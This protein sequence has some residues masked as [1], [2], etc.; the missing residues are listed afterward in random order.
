MIH[1]IHV[2]HMVINGFLDLKLSFAA[3]LTWSTWSTMRQVVSEIQKVLEPPEEEVEDDAVPAW[4]DTSWCQLM[5]SHQLVLCHNLVSPVC[6]AVQ[7]WHSLKS[8]GRS[9]CF[10]CFTFAS[11]ASHPSLQSDVAEKARFARIDMSTARIP[12]RPKD[13]CT[14]SRINM[15]YYAYIIIFVYIY[16][17]IQYIY[18]YI[19]V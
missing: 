1:E 14:Y 4:T 13:T 2:L 18:I 5:P 6:R 11:Y 16:N 15:L 9:T 7:T 3:W 12:H 8:M 10:F 19:Y 17:Y